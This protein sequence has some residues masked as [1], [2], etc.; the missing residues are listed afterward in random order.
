MPACDMDILDH[1][2]KI[3]EISREIGVDKCLSKIEAKTHFD[4]VTAKL[5][6]SPVQAVMFSHFLERNHDFNIK[7]NE[8][9]DSVKCG[10]IKIIKYIKDFDELEKKRL[11]RC[12][13]NRGEIT[14]RVPINVWE[15]LRKFNELKPE[16][17]ENLDTVELFTVMELM[18]EERK[19]NELTFDNLTTGLIELINLNRHLEFCKKIESYRLEDID[20]TL[21]IYFCHLFINEDDDNIGP[22]DLE[23]LYEDKNWFNNVKKQL[24]HGHHNLIE[25]KYIEF[26]NDNNYVDT[27]SWKL[28]D[29][30][31][32]D[33]FPDL[34]VKDKV[35]INKNLLLHDSITMKKM[36]YNKRETEEI[37]KLISLL[38]EDNFKKIQGRLDGKGMRKGFA[39][40]FSG[41]P[42]TG[43]TET[44]YQIAR[45]TKRNI[46]KVDISDIK[47]K[48]YGES[49]KK[50]KGIFDN[51][52]EAVESSDTAPILL[53]NEADAVI[54]KRKE[55][56]SGS[57]SV[58]QT[59]NTI[60]NIILEE[61]ERLSGIL[62]ATTN[63]TQNL[64][65]AF[66]RRFLYKINFDKPS[67]ESRMGIWSALLPDIT[68]EM[69]LVLSEK[70][71]LSGGQIEN[72]A[73]KTEVDSIINGNAAS[74]DTLLKYCKDESQN[75][76]AGTSKKI[77]FRNG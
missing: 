68:E 52:R 29:N 10:Y 32:K 22:Y 37:Q 21:F 47:S 27:N 64:D 49:E 8:I 61:I 46:M 16:K 39:C 24:S 15:S 65:S 50:I 30:S 25:A 62:I 14:Y 54:G 66:E 2:E 44:A 55:F 3:A 56:S 45:E 19:N 31:K 13:R 69:A 4:F 28:S 33:L 23:G 40:L 53:F 26:N 76:F 73:R 38:H 72:I 42:G 67:A 43:K 34:K 75:G 48:W 51:Y 18:F 74:L 60:Q 11:I 9:A 57:R 17:K 5:G 58:D 41:G 59:D 35:N 63:L 36:F 77:G 12:S 20:A 1:I 6:I 7:V 70:H 71:E